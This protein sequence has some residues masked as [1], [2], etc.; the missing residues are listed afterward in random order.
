MNV[1]TS[2]HPKAA[3]A[4][5]TSLV[6]ALCGCAVGP[7]YSPPTPDVPSAWTG[8]ATPEAPQSGISQRHIEDADWWRTFGDPELTS[9]IDRALK[10]NLA[11]QEAV[12]RIEEARA[13]RRALAA[14]AWPSLDANASYAETRISEETATTSLLGT[15]G[16]GASQG[17][18]P[19]GVS[20]ALPGLQNPFSQYQ[21]GLTGSWEIDLFGRI[22]RQVEAADA[23][24]AA[25]VEDSR[26]VDVSLM[27]EVAA[28]YIDLR[29]AQRQRAN[30]EEAAATARG[31]VKLAT[32]A[33]RA[34]IGDDIA[35]A[36]ARAALSTAEAVPP[37]LTVEIATDENQLALLL[38]EKPGAL[39]PELENSTAVPPLPPTV[40]VGLPSELA[41]RR[42]DI[43]EAEA[44]LHAAVAQQ[45]VAV[46]DL[47]PR[48]SIAAALGLEAATPAGLG[49]W[50][51]RYFT[52]GP[53][54]DLPV[55]DAGARQANVRIANVRAK[56]AAIAYAQT[57]LGALHDAENAIMAYEEEQARH[58][59]LDAAVMQDRA[60]LS[61]ARVRYQLGSAGLSDVLNAE[62]KLETAESALI[63]S[64]AATAQ[65]LV[66]LYKSL[67]GGWE[68]GAGSDGK[69]SKA[70]HSH[71]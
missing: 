4:G 9:L 50:A 35:V 13:Q 67:G 1:K 65:D 36:N 12:L 14:G 5:L 44:R 60:A 61:L 37:P 70:A 45:G 27:A 25:A 23:N 42:P 49:A 30:A 17:G 53:T 10:A 41:R 28:A 56:E 71:E 66:T 33:R 7:N 16:G 69:I 31:V 20:S 29:Y 38:A 62:E 52:V 63:S 26:A 18:A 68:S 15:L 48:L 21:Y 51:A 34:E 19:G 40:P 47:Y 57:V 46:A 2:D 22:R 59:S 55:F 6:G 39:D 3:I 8:A 64:T 43:R 11:A 24:T 54:L 32:D 58:V